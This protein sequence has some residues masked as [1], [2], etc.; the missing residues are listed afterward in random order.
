M[1]YAEVIPLLRLPRSLEVFDYKVPID[2]GASISVGQAVLIRFRG[3]MVTGIIAKLKD[4][5]TAAMATIDRLL[6]P[7]PLVDARMLALL[8]SFAEDT[9]VAPGLFL[10]HALPEVPKRT[11]SIEYKFS[12]TPSSTSSTIA[13]D[14]GEKLKVTLA[15][16][17]KYPQAHIRVDDGQLVGP[18]LIRL[19]MEAQTSSK[20]MLVFVPIQE[21]ALT[22]AAYLHTHG[23]P[24]VCT[25]ST[26]AKVKTYA[27]WRA[28]ERGDVPVVVGTR[29]ALFFPLHSSGRYVLIDE[30]A[31]EWKQSDIN[32]RLDAR[33][34]LPKLAAHHRAT[35]ITITP[36]CP[37][38]FP[39]P[40]Y[41]QDARI[42]EP[43]QATITAIPQA[44]VFSESLVA[45]M[46]NKRN[47][48]FFVHRKGKAALLR[49]RDCGFIATCS[50]CD[51]ALAVHRTFLRC[52]ACDTSQDLPLAC[53]KCSSAELGT[54]GVG[55]E[56]VEGAARE[57]FPHAAITVTTSAFLNKW[58]ITE[59][60]PA[61]DLVAIV[62]AD[63]LLYRPDFRSQEKLARI[64]NRL[65]TIVNVSRAPFI[66]QTMFPELAVW[67]SGGTQEDQWIKEEYAGRETL[68]Y[69][70]FWRMAKLIIQHKDQVIARTRALEVQQGLVRGCQGQTIEINEP[71]PATPPKIRG[72]YRY[73]VVLRFKNE[74]YATIKPHLNAL[75]DDVVIDLDPSDVLR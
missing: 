41:E 42:H 35:L 17:Q 16:I 53:S 14:L 29:N 6:N 2:L 13:R 23:V 50:T 74:H 56:Q 4:Q 71:A 45:A 24:A 28:F 63:T 33:I 36:Q 47:A 62:E 20:P 15:A 21:H 51:L 67:T 43:L 26:D 65:R 40:A 9:F 60:T 59:P 34:L 1:T 7:V 8:R 32:P 72:Q 30:T 55:T 48:L 12:P 57:V 68:H 25:L 18:L 3:R 37:V 73:L 19:G 27:L 52:T 58:P 70:P 22:L 5:S 49:C 46:E 11:L 69:P 54:Y 61:F 44:T 66:I 31:E 64:V 10:R 39:A 38:S 75:P